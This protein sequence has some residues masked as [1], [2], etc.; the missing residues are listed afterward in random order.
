M[1]RAYSQTDHIP[2]RSR[3]DSYADSEYIPIQCNHIDTLAGHTAK[4]LDVAAHTN[5]IISGSA[6]KTIGVWNI[7]AKSVSF[8]EGHDIATNCVSFFKNPGTIISGGH[9]GTIRTWDIYNKVPVCTLTHPNAHV[10]DGVMC[11]MLVEDK[12]L[13]GHQNGAIGLWHG[14]S[15]S[16]ICDFQNHNCTQAITSLACY[17]SD[18]HYYIISSSTDAT[19]NIWDFINNELLVTLTG[20]IGPITCL[21]V[22]DD[23]IISGSKDGAIKF[24]DIQNG[25]CIATLGGYADS[26]NCLAIFDNYI[27]AGHENGA[28]TI[29]DMRDKQCV[30][31][32]TGHTGAVTCMDT[33]NN[34][35]VTGSADKTIKL[36]QL[37]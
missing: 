10:T 35:L 13:A 25:H 27:I 6:D 17:H 9:D 14:R 24:W 4:V 26:V 31:V 16:Y 5:R 7:E 2:K 21:K 8:L 28:L 23:F 36:W 12:I 18:S 32:L 33:L 22:V 29:W 3:T 11:I 37:S 15:G 30:N 34:M 19:T 1:K 20:H